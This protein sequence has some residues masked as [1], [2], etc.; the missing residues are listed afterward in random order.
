[1]TFSRLYRTVA[2]LLV[3]LISLTACRQAPELADFSKPLSPVSHAVDTQAALC[4]Q[5]MANAKS[6][7]EL[8][9]YLTKDSYDYADA[10]LIAYPD[11]YTATVTGIGELDSYIWYQFTLYADG[12]TAATDILPLIITDD[13]C[14][15]YANTA[16]IE[17]VREQH[18]CRTCMGGGLADTESTCPRCNGTC[19]QYNPAV[20]Y[21]AG[22]QSWQGQWQTCVQCGGTGK[23][24]S[25]HQTTCTACK[26]VGFLL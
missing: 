19:Q 12:A 4:I 16:Y 6:A 20:Y 17:R 13:T 15:I 24:S 2:V 7:E 23:V 25:S 22:M 10:L 11:T 21:D 8:R 3:L 9:P 1:M 26:G 5:G 18:R 14:R